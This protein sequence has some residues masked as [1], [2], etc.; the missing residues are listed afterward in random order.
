MYMYSGCMGHLSCT[1]HDEK[2]LVGSDEVANNFVIT[3]SPTHALADMGKSV[4]RS[5]TVYIVS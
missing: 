1:T 5:C 4:I 3:S 2:E